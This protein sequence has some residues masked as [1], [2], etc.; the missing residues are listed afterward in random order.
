MR[1]VD[2][3]TPS[4]RRDL[5]T[6]RSLLPYLWEYRSR[7][8]WAVGCLILAKAA[9]VTIPLML[10]GIVDQLDVAR[11]PVLVLPIAFLIGYGAMRLASSAFSELRDAIIA[12]VTQRALRRVALQLIRHLHRLARHQLPSHLHAVQRAAHAGRDHPRRSDPA[13]E[14]PGRLRRH[15]LRHRCPLHHLYADGDRVAHEVPSH[16]E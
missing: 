2:S 1:P 15:H 14:I 13:R 8:L 16:H 12:K 5:K 4:S 11:N 6:I 3:P 7:V 9:T 10:K